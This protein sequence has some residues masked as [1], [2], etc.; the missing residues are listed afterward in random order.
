MPAHSIRYF[1]YFSQ[2]HDEVKEKGQKWLEYV[3]RALEN[4][5]HPR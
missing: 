3:A 5:A 2:S 4:E 1:L